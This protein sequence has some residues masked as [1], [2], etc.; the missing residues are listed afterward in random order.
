MSIIY[1][2]SSIS[3]CGDKIVKKNYKSTSNTMYQICSNSKFITSIVVAKLYELKKLDYDTDV[4]KYLKN[5]EIKKNLTLRHLLSHTSGSSDYNG[6]LGAEPQY[7]LKQNNILTKEIVSGES[8]SKPFNITEKIGKKFMY[9]GAGY[10]LVQKIIEDIT[11]KN[12]YELLKKYIFTPLKMTKSTGKLLYDKKH[13]YKL[14]NTNGMYRMYAETAA[15][16]IWMSPNDMFTLLTDLMNGYNDNKSKILS[17][18]TIKYITKG[19]HP[20]WMN[21]FENYGLG[22]FVNID[23][24]TGDKLFAHSGINYGY[25]SNFS[26]IPQQK[27]INILMI[28]HDPRYHFD[29]I[30]LAKKKLK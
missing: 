15:A 26:V 21:K 14:A 13:K 16:G 20:E 3:Q 23:D 28:N 5:Y 22:M 6:Y 18:K 7:P 25:I 17:Q 24:D 19:E 11:G 9:S 27:K 8:Y 10:Q 12:L 2:A 30:S 4:N 29:V 1:H